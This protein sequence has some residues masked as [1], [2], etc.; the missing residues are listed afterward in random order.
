MPAQTS[1]R[2]KRHFRLA[3]SL[4]G[5]AGVLSQI[6]GGALADAMKA[7]RALVAAGIA[8][9]GIAALILALKPTYLL[10]MLASLLQGMTAGIITPAIGAISLGLVGLR[11][12]S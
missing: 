1:H 8:M 11:K 6:P 12:M 5:M 3:L 10:V 4:G 7:K 9:I 2:K